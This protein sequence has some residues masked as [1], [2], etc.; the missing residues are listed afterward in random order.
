MKFTNCPSVFHE[1]EDGTQ[2]IAVPLQRQSKEQ[3]LNMTKQ[4]YQ[5][6]H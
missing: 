4:N 5:T 6:I 2:I 3:L 1:K